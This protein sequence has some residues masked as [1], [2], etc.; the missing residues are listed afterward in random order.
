MPIYNGTNWSMNA[1]GNPH[2]L[3]FYGWIGQ[4]GHLTNFHRQ[5]HEKQLEKSRRKSQK[6]RLG[7]LHRWH[8][9][10]I[11]RKSSSKLLV[12]SLKPKISPFSTNSVTSLSNRFPAD[13]LM[14][15][16]MR[17]EDVFSSFFEHL[18]GY[19]NKNWL[20]WLPRL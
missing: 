10:Q 1:C 15:V 7:T 19:A 6:P 16:K 5:S 17:L 9:E 11:A 14:V 4:V 13:L 3:P 12:M 20:S 8:N 18:Y 2:V